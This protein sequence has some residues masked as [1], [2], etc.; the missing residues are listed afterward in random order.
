M[1]VVAALL[2]DYSLGG[3]EQGEY[4]VAGARNYE[5]LAGIELLLRFLLILAY[6][7]GGGH[8]TSGRTRAGNENIADDVH[9]HK[10]GRAGYAQGNAGGDDYQVAVVQ[11]SGFHCLLDCVM[12]KVIGGG[13]ALLRHQR[14]YAPGKRLLAQRGFAGGAGDYRALRAVA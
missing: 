9:L 6:A 10:V 14:N 1:A 4:C 13:H 12:D 7:G 2:G 11:E 8:G 3:L 5:N